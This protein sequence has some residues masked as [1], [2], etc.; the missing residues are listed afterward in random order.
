MKRLDEILARCNAATP[1]PWKKDG[2]DD[3]DE[4]N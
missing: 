4:V 1:G 3:T 2:D